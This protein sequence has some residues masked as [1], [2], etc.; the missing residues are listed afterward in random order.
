MVIL[1]LET[2]DWDSRVQKIGY[3]KYHGVK[4]RHVM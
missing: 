4:S 3:I 2:F 1:A